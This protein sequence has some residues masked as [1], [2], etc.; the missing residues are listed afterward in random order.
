MSRKKQKFKSQL[1]PGGVAESLQE[2]FSFGA[3][4]Y[5]KKKKE[6]YMPK[7][8]KVEVMAGKKTV[9]EV[10][11]DLGGFCLAHDREVTGEGEVGVEVI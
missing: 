10:N 2:C 6:K 3:S 9:D 8:L 5:Y 4:M 1:V 7:F 11:I